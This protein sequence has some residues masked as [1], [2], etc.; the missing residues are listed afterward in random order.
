M[1]NKSEESAIKENK[2]VKTASNL[3]WRLFERWGGQ[4]LTF[5]VSII[6]AR[7]LDPTVY[8]TIA[9]V[10]VFTAILEVFVHSGLGN[11]LIQ[12]KDVDDVDFSTVFYFNI[13]MCTVL[14]LILFAF[15]P[16]IANFY[17]D[18]SLS[19]VIRIVGLT[20]LF[21]G[22]TNIQNAYISKKMQFKKFFFSAMSANIISAI[23]GITMAYMG[24]GV[25][26]LVAQSLISQVVAALILWLISKWRPIKAFSL[27]RL[28]GLFSYGWKLL[29]SSL[30]E[31]VYGESR[32]LIIGKRYSAQQLAYYNKGSAFPNIIVN[33]VNSS[34]NSVLFPVLSEEQD[35]RARVKAMTRRA[36][37]TSAY[38]MAPLMIGLAICSERV[39]L[40]LLTEK[41]LSCA[42]FMQIFCVCYLFYPIHTANLNAIKAMGRSDYFLGLQIVKKIIGVTAILI[43]MWISVEA[44]A[45]SLLL[46][47]LLEAM[48]NAFPNKKLLKYS[49]FEQMKDILPY[50]GLACLMGVPVYF[51]GC[52]SLPPIVV[53]LL[54]VFAGGLYY[55][56]I[57]A[58]FKL[59]VFVYLLS[60]IK[61]LMRKKKRKAEREN[62]EK[63]L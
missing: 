55:I 34:I 4:I 25:W 1:N 12:K 57:S 37:R 18:A 17:E 21:S 41:W 59:E 62:S 27:K 3:L 56:G 50:I 24:F 33:N 49:W 52:L 46:T 44:M 61:G 19:P 40:L 60:V 29:V 63:P 45:Y 54:Q 35:D 9:L 16:I 30:L 20:L 53:L 43:T 11:A 32:S 28:K 15:A 23:I 36:I 38:I 48:I 47:T 31:K 7:L 26:A 8:G 13:A 22:V 10:T 14:Y 58:L 5:I 2:T 39:I 42:L 6:L 51:I